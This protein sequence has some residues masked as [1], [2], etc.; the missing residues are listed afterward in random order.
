MVRFELDTKDLELL[1]KKIADSPGDV[2]KAIN[3]SLER[4]GTALAIEGIIMR[5]PVSQRGAKA[6]REKKHARYSNPLMKRM[7]NL[8]F[9]VVAKGGAS[10]KKGSFGYLAFPDEGR[11]SSNPVAHH[12]FNDGVDDRIPRILDAL[13]KALDEAIEL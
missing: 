12:F 11:G 3:Q 1:M 4:E 2:E 8:G 7:E 10:G 6:V 5:M 13:D 9:E